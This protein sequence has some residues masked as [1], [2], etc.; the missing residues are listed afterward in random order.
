MRD[1]EELT[2]VVQ[3]VAFVQLEQGNTHAW[4]ADV[5]PLLQ[6]PFGQ[7][8]KLATILVPGEDVTQAVQLVAFEQVEQGKGQIMHSFEVGRLLQYPLG[9][10]QIEPILEEDYP[11][12]PTQV[13]HAVPFVQVAQVLKQG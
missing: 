9:H 8:Q 12:L 6:Q 10:W 2:Q 3:L 11:V 5:V 13:T 1:G 4:H 7:A